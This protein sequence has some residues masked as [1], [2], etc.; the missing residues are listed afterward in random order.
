MPTFMVI[1]Q[2]VSKS[3]NVKQTNQHS[4]LYMVVLVYMVY[5]LKQPS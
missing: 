5:F 1:G 2:T 4:N 3:I